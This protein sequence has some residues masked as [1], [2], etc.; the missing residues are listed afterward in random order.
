MERLRHAIHAPVPPDAPER[1]ETLGRLGFVMDGTQVSFSLY[2]HV[3]KDGCALRVAPAR[4]RHDGSVPYEFTS[5]VNV[6][7][8]PGTNR[9]TGAG[10]SKDAPH[11]ITPF[12]VDRALD[13]LMAVATLVVHTFFGGDDAR[14]D[15]VDGARLRT[16]RAL[17]DHDND[18]SPSLS[19]LKLMQGNPYT[20][21]G[22]YGFYNARGTPYVCAAY[23]RKCTT[24]TVEHALRTV[25]RTAVPEDR[26]VL[27]W[28]ISTYG[29]YTVEQT[30][31]WL[32][33][34]KNMSELCT[35]EA[36]LVP[37][38]VKF[39]LHMHWNRWHVWHASHGA[40][41]LFV[42]E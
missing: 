26:D 38:K 20:T 9:V 21:Y 14:Y 11:T 34:R 24:T 37:C 36:Y 41:S 8:L 27:A 10:I 1:I 23:A 39:E 35:L 40:P 19:K 12:P 42:L 5:A 2:R 33:K 13:T 25:M 15:L 4:P 29:T 16:G 3:E 22:R 28:L 18:T 6:R 7:Y 30:V 32:L 31:R 17:Y